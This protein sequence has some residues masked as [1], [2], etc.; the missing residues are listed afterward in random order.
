MFP[1]GS[2]GRG[3]IR[4]WKIREMRSK[5][6]VHVSVVRECV[7]TWTGRARA[8]GICGRYIR[9]HRPVFFEFFRSTVKASK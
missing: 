2:Y 7:E 1:F 6:D 3:R 5:K 8:F 9:V 4:D